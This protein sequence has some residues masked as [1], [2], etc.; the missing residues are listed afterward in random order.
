MLNSKKSRLTVNNN[1]NATHNI[2]AAIV[3]VDK[4]LKDEGVVAS[5]GNGDGFP[6]AN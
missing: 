1:I 2:L 4:L 3:D 5:D 6:L